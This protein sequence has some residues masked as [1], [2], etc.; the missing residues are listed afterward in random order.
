[1]SLFRR[2]VISEILSHGGV[3]LSTLIIV[4]LSV[5]I[6][7]LLGDAASGQIGAEVVLGLA[8][9]SSVTALPVILSVSLFIA[10]LTT[11]T[12]SFRESEMVVWFASG[13][14]LAN[15]IRPILYCAIPLSLVVSSLTLYGAPW[16]YRQIAEYHQRYELRSDLSKVSTGEFIETEGGD[17]VFFSEEPLQEGDELGQVVVRVL[18]EE[19]HHLITAESAYTEIADNGD[20]FLVLR[21]GHRYDLTPGEGDAQLFR[22]E[23]YG[24]RM[25]NRDEDTDSEAIRAQAE[26]QLKARPTTS[27][28]DKFDQGSQAHLMWRLAMPLAALNLALLA[29]PL[30]VVNPRLGRGGD[31]LIAGLIALLYMNLINLSRGWINKG[32]LP[33][34]V[35]LW[36]VHLFFA[37]LMVVLLW[38]RLRVKKPKPPKEPAPMA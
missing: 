8:F 33:F 10:V 17:R 4:W 34:E 30:G 1:M 7:R 35:G 36:L 27:L 22:F 28:I 3:V 18:G 26:R 12:R 13:L 38:H 19:W 9:F 2:S 15:W 6:V 32:V 20:R 29:I 11:V 16:A 23:R 21:D 25:E 14:S 5:L 24:V 37:L 31:V